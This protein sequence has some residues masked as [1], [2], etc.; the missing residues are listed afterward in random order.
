MAGIGWIFGYMIDA[1]QAEYVRVPFAENSAYKVP[2]GTTDQEGILLSDILPTG[3]EIGVQYGQ[4]SP[5]DVVGVIGSGPV[6]LSSV[7]TSRL[8]GPSKVIAIDL[9]GARLKGASEF[10]A[11]NVV[12]SGDQDWKEQVMA[13]TDGLRVDVAIAAVG[14]PD[15]FT[16][17]TQIVCHGGHV[18][19]VGVHGKPVELA[20]NELWI[21]NVNI[22]MGLVN[23]NTLGMLL[24]LVAEHKLPAEEFVTHEF[25]FD[26]VLEAYDVFGNAGEYDTLKV[27]IH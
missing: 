6:G 27:L 2:E 1:T 24:K 14:L 26:Q 17:A 25:A 21:S 15:T 16:M 19:N 5:S 18:A 13:L 9:D 8:C 12:N 22:S 10:G 11:T 23:T 7:V 3:F 4:V 20:L